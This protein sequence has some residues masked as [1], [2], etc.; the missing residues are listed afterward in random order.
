MN[1]TCGAKVVNSPMHSIWCDVISTRSLDPFL[2][3]SSAAKGYADS[4]FLYVS[5]EHFDPK[6]PYERFKR[7]LY[8]HWVSTIETPNYYTIR[9]K[10]G[11]TISFIKDSC[12]GNE[13]ANTYHG[14]CVLG[15]NSVEALIDASVSDLVKPGGWVHIIDPDTGLI[16]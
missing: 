13:K 3:L 2:F 5:T 6:D 4:S 16:V 11:A 10:N 7:D 1:C 15:C 12:L 14:A 8:D 9:F